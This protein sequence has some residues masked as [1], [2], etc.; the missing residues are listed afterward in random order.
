[1]SFVIKDGVLQ[2]YISE[3]EAVITVPDGVTVIGK[4]AF[5]KC[6]NLVTV[7][8]PDTVKELE[9]GAFQ[10]CINLSSVQLSNNIESIGAWAFVMCEKLGC[11]TF[12]DSLCS[13]GTGAFIGCSALTKLTIPQN[14]SKIGGGA[15][16]FCE[17]LT[18]I[19]VDP[20]NEKFETESGMLLQTDGEDYA[21]ICC[22]A[23]RIGRVVIPDFI[24]AVCASAFGGCD[25]ITEIIFPACMS[26][27][28]EN[29]FHSCS[30]L[31]SVRLPM[32]LEQ[33]LSGAFAHC[34]Q[35]KRVFIPSSLKKIEANVFEGCDN[36]TIYATSPSY[37]EKYAIK[38]GLRFIANIIA[39]CWIMDNTLI[40]YSYLMKE[41]EVTLPSGITRIGESA[42][43]GN[44]LIK[45][46]VI[47]EGV[48]EIKERAFANCTHL[49]KISLPD[50]IL[51]I[52]QEVFAGCTRLRSITLPDGLTEIGC[53][54]F[55]GCCRL[56]E[57][58]IPHTVRC[59]DSSA[60]RG[61][62][63]LRK[64][65]IPDGIKAIYMFAFSDCH[66]LS[67][68]FLP[69]SINHISDYAFLNCTGLKKLYINSSIEAEADSFK[70]CSS[71]NDVFFSDDVE[72]V[73]DLKFLRDRKD[74]ILHC[75]PH[76]FIAQSFDDDLISYKPIRKTINRNKILLPRFCQKC[77]LSNRIIYRISYDNYELKLYCSAQLDPPPLSGKI[78]A[79]D[80]IANEQRMCELEVVFHNALIE[81]SKNWISKNAKCIVQKMQGNA[82]VLTFLDSKVRPGRMMIHA[83][84]AE[85]KVVYGDVYRNQIKQLTDSILQYII[86]ENNFDSLVTLTLS[87]PL[88]CYYPYKP[89]ERIESELLE[90]AAF[91]D[92]E[93]KQCDTASPLFLELMEIMRKKH[94]KIKK[95][96]AHLP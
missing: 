90:I 50:S 87:L 24:D 60:F 47:P 13:I 44:T 75:Y 74:T 53:G 17:S 27:I 59:I 5:A 35:L 11:I 79:F 12:P 30:A 57:V 71:L 14:V 68:V 61:C 19:A 49:Q 2:S 3:N 36:L 62:E 10:E 54:A 41:K 46:I 33:I 22:P 55:S 96:S 77:D 6:E 31:T 95:A 80:T 82:L 58:S 9:E 84:S 18:D 76:S 43:E 56:N 91:P 29:A 42:F 64:L 92:P 23:G 38:S 93:Q 81:R 67:S 69:K 65:T 40:R 34:K 48:T 20:M 73:D 86:E 8:L 85:I 66:S 45:S 28:G 4:N 88:H 52:G 7:V 63:K 51:V 32:E 37:A 70:G 39:D 21:I 94:E 72:S 26:V 1:M 83:D 89:I 78:S 15:F 25:Q 16:S